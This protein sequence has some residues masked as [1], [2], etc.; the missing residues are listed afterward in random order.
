MTQ[1]RD[2]SVSILNNIID[3]EYISKNL[4]KGIFN[5]SIWKSK[6]RHEQCLWD[7]LYF[8]DIYKSKLKQMCAN[9]IPN[10]YIKNK[11]LLIKLKN[12][13]FLPHEI[14]FMS[15]EKL[16]PERWEKIIQEK[17]K[18]DAVISEID[19]GLATNQFT[20]VKCKGNKTTYYTMQTRSAD[21][22]ETIFITCLQCN[23]RWRK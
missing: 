21:E 2:K 18:R 20:C 3:D 22:A 10:S 11:N 7:N 23:R 5:Y 4:E 9:L 19:F 6:E 8:Q 13:E 12:K 14:V 16:F 15:P 1:L 17:N